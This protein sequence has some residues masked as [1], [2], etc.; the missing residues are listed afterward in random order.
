MGRCG[1]EEK[2]TR[3]W[4]GYATSP[5]GKGHGML[6]CGQVSIQFSSY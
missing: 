2:G 3:G 5:K 4:G 6:F 1:G